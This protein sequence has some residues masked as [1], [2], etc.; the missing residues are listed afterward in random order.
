MVEGDDLLRPGRLP[1]QPLAFGVVDPGDDVFVVEVGGGG[2]VVDEDEALAVERRLGVARIVH[3]HGVLDII[4][5][6]QR[7]ARRRLV[8]VRVRLLTHRRQEVQRRDDAL[9]P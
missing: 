1:H 2:L 4:G 3:S 7:D 6:A 9:Q 5:I 8:I